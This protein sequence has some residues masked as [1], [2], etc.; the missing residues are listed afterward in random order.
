M[1]GIKGKDYQST[2]QWEVL[3]QGE[4]S[5]NQNRLGGGCRGG[6][7]IVS[8]RGAIMIEPGSNYV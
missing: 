3:E 7:I 4:D 8:T 5:W 6:G 2:T 1:C